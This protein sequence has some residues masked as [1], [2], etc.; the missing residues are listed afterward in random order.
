LIIPNLMVADMAAS[1][2]FYRGLLGFELVTAI[3]ATRDVLEAT[4]GRDA[5]FAVLAA[6]G[7]QLMLQTSTSLREELPSLAAHAA[8]TG[9]IYVRGLDP[10]ALA[11]PAQHVVK[12]IERQWYGML[13]M[14]LRDPDGYI[15]CAGCADGPPVTA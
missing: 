14:Y 3:S 6:Q 2:A 9:T 12:P 7:G 1:L 10:R 8:F 13:E 4:D 11:I 5:V 15:V